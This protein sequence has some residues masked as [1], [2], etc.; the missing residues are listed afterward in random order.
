MA[1]TF[2]AKITKTG[3]IIQ[4]YTN[5][6]LL[7]SLSSPVAIFLLETLDAMCRK[8]S[9]SDL[10]QKAAKDPFEKCVYI[11]RIL[12]LRT[13]QCQRL[14]NEVKPSSS[15]GRSW[16]T[17]KEYNVVLRSADSKNVDRTIESLQTLTNRTDYLI[18]TNERRIKL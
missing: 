17:Q 14:F 4:V 8:K 6:G 18:I 12:V 15:P 5:L 1:T 10:L 3:K 13:V 7:Q 16:S 2:L 11:K 9:R